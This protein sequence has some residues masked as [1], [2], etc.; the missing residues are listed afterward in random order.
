MRQ[1]ILA[2]ISQS[3]CILHKVLFSSTPV[4][5]RICLTEQNDCSNPGYLSSLVS[6]IFKIRPKFLLPVA[7]LNK[8]RNTNLTGNSQGPCLMLTVTVTI[9]FYIGRHNQYFFKKGTVPEAHERCLVKR[10]NF[11]VLNGEQ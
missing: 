7:V 4:C 6:S 1:M 8:Y 3:T 9:T 2:N 11:S 10:K 5:C